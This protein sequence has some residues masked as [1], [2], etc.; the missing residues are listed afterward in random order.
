MLIRKGKTEGVPQSFGGQA[1]RE[2]WGATNVNWF[3][4]GPYNTVVTSPTSPSRV[5]INRALQNQSRL[6]DPSCAAG[7]PE[8]VRA[9]IAPRGVRRPQATSR[10]AAAPT[11]AVL[12]LSQN[13]TKR[14]HP[15]ESIAWPRPWGPL[16]TRRAHARGLFPSRV[17][18]TN[19]LR[20]RAGRGRLAWITNDLGRHPA[21]PGPK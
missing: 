10:S 5:A 3:C 13:K 1:E 17:P 16:L 19:A 14:A 9:S 11:A 7:S 15:A 2:R 12:N 6:R 8:P 18:H 4:G 21:Q 20:S